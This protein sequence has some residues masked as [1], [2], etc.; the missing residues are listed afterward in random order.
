MLKFGRNIPGMAVANN[1]YFMFHILCFF[2][3]L[4]PGLVIYIAIFYWLGSLHRRYIIMELTVV[5]E[6][7]QRVKPV[8][9][10]QG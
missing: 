9:A 6:V 1:Y 8:E 4:N 10:L 3:T 5:V 7:R 2:R